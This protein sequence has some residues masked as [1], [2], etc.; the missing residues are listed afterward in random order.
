M[1]KERRIGLETKELTYAVEA[2][3]ER[4]SEMVPSRNRE[5]ML[6]VL[7]HI[8][9]A[10]LEGKDPQYVAGYF[11]KITLMLDGKFDR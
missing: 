2:T 9:A 10:A 3:L 6:Q 1:I 4:L 7:A 5:D 11:T 8:L